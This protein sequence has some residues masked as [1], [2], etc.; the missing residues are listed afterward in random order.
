MR[1]GA[2][3]K[4]YSDGD[5]IVSE[6][7]T[8]NCMYV[9][10]AGEVAV[11]RDQGGREIP[12]ATLGPGDV[13]GEMALFTKQPRSATVRACGEAR[14]L[15]V[16]KRQFLRRTHEDPSLAFELLKRMSERIEKLN[17]VI[18]GQSN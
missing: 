5:V 8:G 9:V 17:K 12:L 1:I 18:A 10:Q 14:I 3:G 13:F 6:G 2:L 16:D 7:E 4:L 11:A 15:T